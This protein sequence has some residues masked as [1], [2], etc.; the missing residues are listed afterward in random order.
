MV[1]HTPKL[2]KAAISSYSTGVEGIQTEPVQYS[3]GVSSRTPLCLRSNRQSKASSSV[4]VRASLQTWDGHRDCWR[5]M[6]DY[7]W[8]VPLYPFVTL[9]RMPSKSKS[10]IGRRN[11]PVRPLLSPSPFDSSSLIIAGRLLVC[12]PLRAEHKKVHLL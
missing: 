1:T 10:P 6:V 2:G 7:K 4:G 12:G 5:R 9:P 3:E 11:I 8:G